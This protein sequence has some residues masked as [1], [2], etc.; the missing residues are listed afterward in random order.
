MTEY[1]EREGLGGGSG[2]HGERAVRRWEAQ[3]VLSI[4][5]LLKDTGR[6]SEQRAHGTGA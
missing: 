6:S 3:G 5:V 4:G 1:E 2:R